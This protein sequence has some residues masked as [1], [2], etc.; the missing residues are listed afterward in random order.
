MSPEQA[1]GRL[2]ELGPASDVYS[3]GA[4]LYS[5]LTGRVPFT[6]TE[7]GDVLR[8]VQ[9][10]DFPPP[11]QVNRAVPPALEMQQGPCPALQDRHFTQTHN[12]RKSH[13]IIIL[14]SP[15]TPLSI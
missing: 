9:A 5:L 2:D 14:P 12:Q 7:L 6:D 15:Y 4:M 8:K 11:R 13:L 1:A 3:L 10:G